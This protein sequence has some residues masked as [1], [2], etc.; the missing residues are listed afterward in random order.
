MIQLMKKKFRIE[1]IL[2][3]MIFVLLTICTML[4]GMNQNGKKELEKLSRGFYSENIQKVIIDGVKESSSVESILK[5]QLEETNNLLIFKT[6]LAPGKDVRGVCYCGEIERPA[7]QEGRFFTP[8]E[9]FS[10]EPLI[11]IGKNYVEET[12]QEKDG[13]YLTVQGTKCR[14]IGILGTKEESRYD[15]MQLLNISAALTVYGGNGTYVVDGNEPDVIQE[16]TDSLISKTEKIAESIY[17][18]GEEELGFQ[19]S[20]EAEEE[21]SQEDGL[22]NLY[23]TMVASFLLAAVSALL[24]WFRHKKKQL[25]IER[26]LG[27]GR[28]YMF[29]QLGKSFLTV[30]AVSCL[31][32]M[33]ATKM[34]QYLWISYNIHLSDCLFA[35]MVTFV[36]G[37]IL[38]AAY[39]LTLFIKSGVIP[40]VFRRFSPLNLVLVLQFSCFFWLFCQIITYYVNINTE[41]WVQNAKNGYQYYT[42][43]ENWDEEDIG[44]DPMMVENIKKALKQVKSQSDFTFMSVNKDGDGIVFTDMLKEHFGDENYDDFLYMSQYPGYFSQTSQGKPEVQ[45]IN[46]EPSIQLSLCR[47]DENAVRHYIKKVSDGRVFQKADYELEIHSK[48]VPVL[49]G[50]AYGKYFKVGD[51][52]RLQLTK[53]VEA[54]V[55][56]ILSENTQYISDSTMEQ[57]GYQITTLDYKIIL[58][59]FDVNGEAV[60]KDDEVFLEE[61]YYNYLQGTLVFEENVSDTAILKAQEKINEIYL[62]NHLYTVSTINATEGLKLFMKETRQSVN[63]IMFLLATMASFGIFSVCISLINK[64]NQN[65]NRYAIEIM[66]GQKLTRIIGAYVVE[67][68]IIMCIATVITG[69]LLIRFIRSNIQFLLILLGI[70]LLVIIPCVFVLVLKFK[71]LN[72]EELLCRKDR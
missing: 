13:R 34:I 17:H 61:N 40:H 19:S 50:A 28:G 58:P 47:M 60:S 66:N 67:V 45:D 43:Y 23:I 6:G 56:G 29:F 32:G 11:L 24:F 53:E 70:M 21:T 5:N 7:V 41:P 3:G 49:L 68:V 35:G 42:L 46:G 51:T 18:N 64:L 10:E 22:S 65:L 15:D 20:E 72:V 54:E 25:E 55:I 4:I 16:A 33:G 37:M 31:L 9:C 14:V 12:Q 8:E 57:L 59:Y 39:G 38:L 62:A 69:Y 63:I 71:M 44:D 36:P 27:A 48:K 30:W 2:L 1:T 52:F 26:F